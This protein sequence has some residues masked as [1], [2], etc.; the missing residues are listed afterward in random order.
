M[1]HWELIICFTDHSW[2]T[3]YGNDV[4]PDT[5]SEED[6]YQS[7]IERYSKEKKDTDPEIAY[8]LKK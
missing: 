3:D 6:V 8:V 1:V 7:Y 2:I 5:E 4:C